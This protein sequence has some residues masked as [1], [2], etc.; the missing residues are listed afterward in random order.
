MGSECG[1]EAREEGAPSEMTPPP[2]HLLHYRFHSSHLLSS[3]S[4]PQHA[5]ALLAKM[6]ELRRDMGDTCDLTI[7]SDDAGTLPVQTHSLAMAAASPYVLSQITR[8]SEGRG[9]GAAALSSSSSLTRTRGTHTQKPSSHLNTHGKWHLHT[10]HLRQI[11]HC[12]NPHTQ[13]PAHPLSLGV[14]WYLANCF[15]EIVGNRMIRGRTQAEIV[16][17]K[18]ARRTSQRSSSRRKRRRRKRRRGGEG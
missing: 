11:H 17:K 1:K 14:S 5:A 12:L 15:Q 3:H 8:W 7:R 6:D 4:P 18:G 2:P 9:S 10:S 16:G 13:I